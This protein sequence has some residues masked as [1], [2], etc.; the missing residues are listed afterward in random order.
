MNQ[1][2]IN[3]RIQALE[4]ELAGLKAE[5]IKPEKFMFKY[6]NTRYNIGSLLEPIKIESITNNYS[7]TSFN[8]RKIKENA[9]ADFQLQK[10]LMCIGAIA[11]QI[12][13]DYKSRV[14]WDS[15]TNWVVYWSVEYEQ[16]RV[17]SNNTIKYIGVVYMPK[18]VA[19]KVCEILNNKG[20]EL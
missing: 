1:E 10:E 7:T 14:I 19:D 9:Q 17:S 2:A 11:E 15:T 12:D 3:K 18:D 13:P 20:I 6:C 5:L 16:Y 8:Y 4:S